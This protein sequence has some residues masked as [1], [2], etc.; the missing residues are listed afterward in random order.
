MPNKVADVMGT[1]NKMIEGDIAK[2]R[3]EQQGAYRG[4]ELSLREREGDR[5]HEL[6]LKELEE[7]ERA[8]FKQETA[9]LNGMVTA[10]EIKHSNS[11][12]AQLEGSIMDGIFLTKDGTKYDYTKKNKKKLVDKFRAAGFQDAESMA[13]LFIMQSQGTTDANGNKVESANNENIIQIAQTFATTLAADPTK[14]NSF[15][16]AG[17]FPENEAQWSSLTQNLNQILTLRDTGLQLQEE[18]MG[19]T[20]GDLE[21]DRD[22]HGIFWDM[23][24]Q[25]MKS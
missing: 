6:A 10:A 21:Y 5:A 8:R 13:R 15:I 16:D 22:Y 9:E 7:K 4:L 1:L 3:A 19:L 18:L 2:I 11:I 24:M 17:I 14:I 23:G 25:I 12:Y 20:R